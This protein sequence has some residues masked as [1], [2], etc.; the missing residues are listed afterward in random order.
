MGGKTSTSTSQVTIPPEVLARYNSVNQQAQQTAQTPFQQYSTNPNAFVAPLTGTQLA[1]ISATNANSQIAQP[2]YNAATGQLEAAQTDTAPSYSAA[3]SDIANAQNV[4]TGLAGGSLSALYGANTAAAPLNAAAG[5]GYTSALNAAS[6]YNAGA[7]GLA[8]GGAEQV[9]PTALNSQAI[10]QYLS[11]YLST[12]LQ[13]TA[14]V[15]NQQNQQQQ[16]GQLGNA[17]NQGAFGGDRAGIA[18][19]NLEEQQNLANAQI[20]S[21]ILN[22]GY[23]TALSTAQQQQGVGL[24]AGQANRAALQEAAGQLQGIGQQVYGQGTTTAEQ[25]QA[26]AQQLYGQGLGTSQQLQSLGQQQFGQG[27]TAA[28]AT[29]GLGQAIYGTGAATS[30]GLANLGAGAQGT[31]LQGAQAQLAA[32]QAAQQT[33]QAGLTALYNQF[34][35]QQSYPF[36]VDQFLANIAEGTG[37]LSGSTTTTTQPQSIFSDERLKEDIRPIGKS[38]DG[39]T[40]YSF[41][42]K[43]ESTPRIGLLAQEVEKKHPEAVGL[44]SGYKTV[45]YDKATEA[46]ADRGHFRRGGLAAN[47]NDWEEERKAYAYG[48]YPTLPGMTPQDLGAILQ[49]QEQMYAPFSQTGALYGGQAGGAP[50]GG[51]SYVPAANLPVSHLAVA[52]PSNVRPP[53]SVLQD[54]SQAANLGTSVDKFANTGL[55]QRIGSGIRDTFTTPGGSAPLTGASDDTVS[56]Y[57]DQGFAP[58]SGTGSATIGGMKRGGNV[59]P[60]RRSGLASGGAPDDS[61][62]DLPYQSQFGPGLNIP[63]TQDKIPSLAV[64][65]PPGQ[66]QNNG[67]GQIGSLLSGIAGIAGLFKKG[68]RVG[69]DDGGDVTDDNSDALANGLIAA[70]AGAGSGL[71]LDIGNA[72]GAVASGFLH[73]DTDQPGPSVRMPIPPAVVAKEHALASGLASAPTGGTGGGG[74]ATTPY[75]P[76]PGALS[77]EG[78][79]PLPPGD[80]NNASVATGD[81]TTPV[82]VAAAP[83]ATGL[84]SGLSAPGKLTTPPYRDDQGLASN[85]GSTGA[86]GSAG[87]TPLRTGFMSD[88][89]APGGFLSNLYH[90]KMSS[91]GPLLQGIAAAGAVPTV[92]PLVAL[93]AGLGGGA[94]A[95]MNTKEQQAQIA[96]TQA[97]TGLE[98]TSAYQNMQTRAPPYTQMVPGPSPDGDP[99]KSFPGPNGSLWHLE[100][101][102]QHLYTGP[103]TG[104]GAPG[105]TPTGARRGPIQPNYKTGTP[106]I[107]PSSDTDAFMQSSYG[108]QPGAAPVANHAMML[109]KNP[110]LAPMEEA[111][112]QAA[113][114]RIGN[115]QDVD[116]T[117]RQ[118]L[119]LS[120]AVNDLSPTGFAGAGADFEDRM[121]LLNIYQTYAGMLGLPADPSVTNAVAN[122]QI[123]DKIKALSGVALAHQAGDRAA[124]I[125][126][127][128]SSVLPG[129]GQ[130]PQ[131]ANE[132]LSTMMVQNQSQ[133]DFAQYYQNYVGG[134]KQYGTP[135]GVQQAFARDMAPVY[136]KE[137][138][139]LPRMMARGPKGGPSV[140]EVA[141]THPESASTIEQGHKNPDGTLLPGYGDGITRYWR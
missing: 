107:A 49:A 59:I 58:P 94:Q 91:W 80:I 129:G 3:G 10:D 116:T 100:I 66:Q 13:G 92:H 76:A 113:A 46:A 18:A 141:M 64:A 83:Q 67:L 140:G 71:P 126:Q 34:L 135:L 139:A 28:G 17:I 120:T 95:Y 26:L 122:S 84:A 33:Q 23:N 53:P 42:Y 86:G 11:P 119:Q 20:Y 2:Y 56:Q 117:H 133:R 78:R 14:G 82:D 24:E 124:V 19:A 22:Q 15:L 38:F 127:S 79:A 6:P 61:S 50:R 12:V 96:Q 55:G 54:V 102:A 138:A 27:I 7:T 69:Y 136:D 87:P 47:D 39:Q 63:D 98:Q 85:A 97:Y 115:L 62:L 101:T 132:I 43:G 130:K 5:T 110:A 41:H 32:G 134:L 57:E 131:A 112:R 114:A 70:G 4:G 52:N 93:A 31:A 73:P 90:G 88:A 8:I 105:T 75:T 111:D 123:I 109:A 65:S 125:A 51:S 128:L 30:E 103:T 21:G 72:L 118:L 68:G 74:L 16:S 37:A 35:Q 9:N 36:Q 81:I 104:P 137:Q 89:T 99:T 25:Q 29:Q 1:G 108:I 45:D 106:T 121:H 77:M 48:G 44:A 40:I 60:F